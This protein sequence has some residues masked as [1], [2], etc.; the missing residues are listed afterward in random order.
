M[1]RVAIWCGF[2]HH[3]IGECR[4]HLA[5]FVGDRLVSTVGDYR[6]TKD[7]E[8]KA[9]GAGADSF[10]E[11]YVFATDGENDP[12]TGHPTVTDWAELEGERFAT[13]EQAHAAHMRI[14]E[15]LLGGGR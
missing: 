2:Q 5:T 15:R 8:Q 6:P 13:P 12:A 7:G 10:Y 1:S 3:F 4:F 11:T 14:V 9:L